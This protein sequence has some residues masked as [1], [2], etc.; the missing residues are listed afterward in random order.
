MDCVSVDSKGNLYSGCSKGM[1]ISW[2]VSGG[3]LAQDRKVLDV[4]KIDKIDCGILSM[5][6]NQDKLLFGTNSSSIF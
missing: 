4:S 5:D 1:I 3:K 2:K 6:F